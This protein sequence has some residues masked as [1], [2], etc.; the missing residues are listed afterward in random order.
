MI[1]LEEI[2]LNMYVVPVIIPIDTDVLIGWDTLNKYSS[3]IN[4]AEECRNYAY[5]SDKNIDTGWVPLQDM[6]PKY[7]LEML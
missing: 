1:E 7:F 5:T 3:S 2:K 6:D 4:A